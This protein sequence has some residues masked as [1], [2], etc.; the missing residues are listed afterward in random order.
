MSDVFPAALYALYDLRYLQRQDAPYD[1]N[2]YAGNIIPGTTSIY[3]IGSASRRWAH[4][5]A[6]AISLGGVERN[7]WPTAVA[8]S[9]GNVFLSGSVTLA[10]QD[11]VT[12]THNKGDTNYLIKVTPTTL[13]ALG[14]LGDIAVVKSANTVVIYNSGIGGIT[15][16][17]ELSVIA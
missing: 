3:D 11:G 10:G 12:V 4:V 8:G 6:D 2:L 9:N 7:S 17:I 13:N 1:G 5:Y 14:M 16:N 15:A